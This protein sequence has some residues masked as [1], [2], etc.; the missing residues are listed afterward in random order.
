MSKR[1]EQHEYRRQQLLQIALDQFITKGFYGTSTREISKIAGISSGLVFNYFDSK[2]SLF[3]ALVENGCDK[4]VLE[5]EPE[6]G[7]LGIF[8]RQIRGLLQMIECNPSAAKMFVFMGYASYNAAKISQKAGDLLEQH[9]IIRQSVPLIQEGQKRGEIR[10]GNPHAL[11]IALWCS[12]Q[13]IAEE[14]ALNPNSPLPQAD[15]IMDILRSK[16]GRI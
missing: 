15:W 8:E 4:L 12:V 10:Q 1:A 5:T 2:E 7:P 9:D 14:I 16:E 3:E 6:C 11:A 13:G